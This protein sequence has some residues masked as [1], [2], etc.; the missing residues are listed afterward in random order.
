M[1][2]SSY[3]ATFSQDEIVPY[4]NFLETLEKRRKLF[5]VCA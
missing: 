2:L 5:S 4:K 3:R 1:K